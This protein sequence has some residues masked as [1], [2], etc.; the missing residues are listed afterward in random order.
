MTND[1][2]TPWPPDGNDP[3][4]TDVVSPEII[5]TGDDTNPEENAESFDYLFLGGVQFPGLCTDIGGNNP[6]KWDKKDAQGSSGATLTYVGD[7]LSSFSVKLQLG[8]GIDGL[9]LAEEWS[10]WHNVK[11]LLAPPTT[12]KPEALEI[13]HPILE[14]LPVPIHAVIVEDVS[15]F[16]QVTHGIWEVEIKLSQHRAPKPA[17]TKSDGTKSGKG[18]GTKDDVDKLIDD[19]AKD[20]GNLANG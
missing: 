19:L 15:A 3:N 20:V 1:A 9:S 11:Y 12:K 5:T 8:W 2:F 7:G 17:N 4:A 10:L 18:N 13:Y 6:R 16:K 14:A